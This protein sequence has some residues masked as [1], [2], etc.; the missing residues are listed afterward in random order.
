MCSVSDNK[1]IIIFDTIRPDFFKEIFA[2]V[3]VI[4]EDNNTLHKSK[5][6]ACRKF[7]K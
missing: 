4:K 2:Y 7:K 6:I 1:T 5:R 3:D